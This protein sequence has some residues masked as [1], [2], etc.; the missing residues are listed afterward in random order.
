VDELEKRLASLRRIWD[1]WK[2]KKEES[3]FLFFV[4][5]V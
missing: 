1:L 3:S 5:S 2:T 4:I